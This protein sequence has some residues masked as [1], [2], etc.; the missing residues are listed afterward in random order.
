MRNEV[1]PLSFDSVATPASIVRQLEDKSLDELA[2][3]YRRAE[4]AG[5]RAW[6]LAALVVLT[7]IDWP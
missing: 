1:Q 3:M 2:A 7:E 4:V 5:L 6:M